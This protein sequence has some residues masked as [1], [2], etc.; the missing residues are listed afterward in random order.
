MTI[1]TLQPLLMLLAS[2]L[3]V[4]QASALSCIQ[5]T[6]TD[7]LNSSHSVFVGKVLSVDSQKA[8]FEIL[9]TWKGAN[10]NQIT[11]ENTTNWTGLP[12]GNIFFGLGNTYI[13]STSIYNGVERNNIDCSI[14]TSLYS[15]NKEAEITNILGQPRTPNSGNG[16]S[17]YCPNLSSNLWL[18]NWYN[19]R[20]EVRELQTFLFKYYGLSLNPTGYYGY[21]TKKYVAQFQR[22]LK[23]Y[24]ATGGVGPLTRAAIARVC[25]NGGGG[26][27]VFCP[28][29]YQPV[30]AQPLHECC[31]TTGNKP[32][33]CMYAKVKCEVGEIKTYGNKCEMNRDGAQYLYDGECN[34]QTDEAPAS[35]KVWYDGCNT[36]SRQSVGGPLMCTMMACF[37]N[38]GSYCKEYFNQSSQ[39]PVIKSFSGPV[40]LRIGEKGT[41]NVQAEIFNNQQ[42]TYNIT[43]GDER[44]DYR[45]ALPILSSIS[46][47]TPQNTSFEHYYA[48]SGNYTVTITV[49]AANGQSTK[50]TSTVNVVY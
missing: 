35:C 27:Q 36:C 15:Y 12:G 29:V 43:W 42:L 24:P 49:T 11:T 32:A 30:C 8:T 33:Y 47:I 14:V 13:V 48:Y 31:K 46:A 1:K 3:F 10:S 18:G 41:W 22:E 45:T 6:L 2:G 40:Q 37:R 39:A 5:T 44:S 26:E 25:G 23:L 7:S 9:K 50:T 38:A 20:S 19:N 16:S 34:N 28:A 4:M 21:S 17:G